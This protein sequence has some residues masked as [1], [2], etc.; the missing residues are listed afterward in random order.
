MAGP[1]FWSMDDAPEVLRFYRDFVG[2]RPDELMT[3]AVQRRMPAL[4]IVPP[5]FRGKP[6]IV[7]VCL[8]PGWVRG[9]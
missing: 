8:L 7:V 1:V 2:D 4:P 9:G 3:I 6:V 5:E